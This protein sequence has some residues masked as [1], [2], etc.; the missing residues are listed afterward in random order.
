MN[1][2]SECIYCL[3]VWPIMPILIC[4]LKT[5]VPSI[6]DAILMLLKLLIYIN[7]FKGYSHMYRIGYNVT[8]YNYLTL[9]YINNG[10]MS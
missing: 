9:S 7:H 1:A 3:D 5:Y 10:L 4:I 8:F 2:Q 6:R